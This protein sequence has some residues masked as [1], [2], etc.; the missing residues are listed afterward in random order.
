MRDMSDNDDVGYERAKELAR[1]DDVSIRMELA[2]RQDLPPELLYFLAEDDAPQVRQVVAANTAAPRQTD[3]L[4]ANDSSAEVREGLA[5]KIAHVAPG[6]SPE[7][8]NKIRAQTYQALETLAQDQMV[9][10]RAV[11]SDAIKDVTDAPPE[12]INALARD[13][14][15]EV[16]GPVLEHSPVLTDDDLIEIIAAGPAQGGVAAIARRDGVSENLADA[17]I[18]TDDL[19]GIGDLLDN[20]SAQIRESALDDL[21]DRSAEIEMWQEPL[22]KRAKLPDGAAERM[23]GF[24]ADNF[25]EALRQRDDLGVDAMSAVG[26]IVRERLAG[27]A[28]KKKALSASFDF[29][30]VATPIDAAQRLHD[31]DKLSDEMMSKAVQAG[32]HPFFFAGLLVRAGIPETVGRRIFNERSAFGIVALMG[33]AGLPANL[34]PTVQKQMGRIAPSDLV[35]ADDE[36]VFPM[37]DEDIDWHIEFFRNMTER[38]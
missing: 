9:K 24:I 25:L 8:S 13:L 31:A 15:L 34:L 22:V 26:A 10:V 18:G 16:S 5:A 1:S 19:D 2:G 20:G 38:G 14:A 6:L 3:L 12:I 28:K 4:L 33:K 11:L 17:I 21:I 7:E 23:A 27:G 37:T 32:D 29:L 30:K 36:D 35:E